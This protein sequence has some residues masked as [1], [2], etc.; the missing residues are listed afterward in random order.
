MSDSPHRIK[1]LVKK[2]LD[3]GLSVEEQMELKA[4]LEEEENVAIFESIIE[5][6]KEKLATLISFRD[7]MEAT[8]PEIPEHMLNRLEA[9]VEEEL[10]E[11][12]RKKNRMILVV[13]GVVLVALILI[14]AN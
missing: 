2:A 9:K 3:E 4:L 14:M 8:G 5:G 6:Y 13:V 7:A 1:A 12:R 11:D 10:G